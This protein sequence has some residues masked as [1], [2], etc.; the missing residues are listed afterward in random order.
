MS[1]WKPRGDRS[2]PLD[3]DGAERQPRFPTGVDVWPY[4]PI[5]GMVS[6]FLA[7]MDWRVWGQG[8]G[9]NGS[10]P[11]YQP[12]PVN[13]AWQITVPGLAKVYSPNTGQS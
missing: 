11:S 4:P 1:I 8:F 2:Y 9:K 3:L 5:I 12:F 7:Q 10:G 13:L 6:G